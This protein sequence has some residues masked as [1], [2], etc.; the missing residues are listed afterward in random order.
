[1]V[2]RE[3]KM[4]F[5][6]FYEHNKIGNVHFGIIL[7]RN[8]ANQSKSNN[9]AKRDICCSNSMRYCHKNK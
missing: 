8:S 4:D 9:M 7:I 1:M 2:Y 3:G 5:P 6:T